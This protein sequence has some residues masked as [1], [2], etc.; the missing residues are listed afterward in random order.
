MAFSTPYLKENKVLIINRVL[1]LKVE[2]DDDSI[3]LDSLKF[4]VI[5]NS[6]YESFLKDKFYTISKYAAPSRV[7]SY[8]SI[9]NA[10][11]DLMEGK[12]YAVFIDEIKANYLLKNLRSANI[13][14]KK[15]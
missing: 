6:A 13:Y 8:D 15:L 12:I 9:E 7:V 1:D 4:C 5:K 2:S 14:T 11:T 10:M 3:K